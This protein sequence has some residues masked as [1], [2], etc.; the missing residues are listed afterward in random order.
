MSHY[1]YC[2]RRNAGPGLLRWV[3]LVAQPLRRQADKAAALILGAAITS[4]AFAGTGLS[5]A[6]GILE[7]FRDELLTIIPIVAIIALVA[8][9]IGYAT[10]FVEKDTFVRWAIGI[11][12]AGS[13]FVERTIDGE[14]VTQRLQPGVVILLRAGE[15]TLWRVT[16][17]LR[18]VYLI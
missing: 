14:Q 11:I 12:I 10:K 5:K 13:G 6:K 3:V 8:L 16:E 9:G 15:E 17:T 18:K 4:P 2:L 1:A 7:T